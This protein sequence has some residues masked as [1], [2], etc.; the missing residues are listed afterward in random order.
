MINFAK[1]YEGW[2]NKLIP[3]AHL[4]ELINATANERIN[5]CLN[6][7]HHSRFHKT[8]RPDSH[9][10]DCGCT[11]SAKTRCLSCS[12]PK[13]KWKAIVTDEEEDTLKKIINGKEKRSE[14]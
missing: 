1:I 10:I 9:C 3:P 12:C 8:L 5:I 13:D 7:P 4:T 2:R 11:L 14:T 6:C